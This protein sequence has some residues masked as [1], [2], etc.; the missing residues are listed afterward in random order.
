ME[1]LRRKENAQEDQSVCDSVYYEQQQNIGFNEGVDACK[2]LVKA[3]AA[4]VGDWEESLQAE[5]LDDYLRLANSKHYI[6]EEDMPEY[7]EEMRNHYKKLLAF[8]SSSITQAIA[9]E[10][11]R[12]MMEIERQRMGIIKV[13]PNLDINSFASGYGYA[14]TFVKGLLSS[15]DK[16]L[17]DNK[18][19]DE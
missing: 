8:I 15:L 3:E 18:K 6:K 1:G 4:V 10:R 7:M 2:A 9:E 17:T 11:E 16:P 14:L 13:P 5:V 12:V 19:D